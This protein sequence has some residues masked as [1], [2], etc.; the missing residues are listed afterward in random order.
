[1]SFRE[2]VRQEVAAKVDHLASDGEV[3]HPKWITHAIC[4]DHAPGLNAD[5]SEHADFW[6]EGGYIA[7]RSEV[8]DYLRKRYATKPVKVADQPT[9]PGFEHLQAHYIVDRDGEE[10]VVPTVNLT[11][12]EIDGI[13]SRLRAGSA[14]LANHADE[15]LR[16]KRLRTPARVAA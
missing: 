16:F 2:R 7:V 10:L 12:D 8:G 1:M 13:V 4:S 15:F 3:L 11:D 6:R 14:T 9:L 5:E